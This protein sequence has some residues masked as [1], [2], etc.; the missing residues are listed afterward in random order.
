M[1][2]NIDKVPNKN[3]G[4]E[5]QGTKQKFWFGENQDQLFKIGKHK[6]ENWAEIVAYHLAKLLDIPCAEYTPG[7]SQLNKEKKIGVISKSFIKKEEGDRLINANELLAKFIKNYDPSKTYKQRS[8]TFF[9]SISLIRVINDELETGKYPPIKQFIGYLI[10]DIWIANQDRHH[11][12]WGFVAT[13]K[14]YLAPSF[15][16]ASSMGCR[17]SE[18]EKQKRLNT[19][20]AGYSVEAFANKA[21]TAMYHN[22]KILK[23]Y[24]LAE[25]CYKYYPKEYCFWVNK[26]SKISEQ[27]IGQCFNYIPQNWMSDI[28]KQFTMKLLQANK[29]ELNKLC[30]KN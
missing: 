20:D 30:V 3:Q 17:V 29:D 8:Y 24:E 9:G 11:E 12:N 4:T 22:D 6:G 14:F 28:D 5:H 7:V 2:K 23:T 19:K 13:T 10:F 16:H 26:I 1:S 21:K 18:N 15:D 27:N 25:L